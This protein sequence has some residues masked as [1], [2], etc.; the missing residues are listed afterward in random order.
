MLKPAIRNGLKGFALASAASLMFSSVSWGLVWGEAPDPD[1][2]P[3]PQ[4]GA[5]SALEDVIA[6]RNGA[7]ASEAAKRLRNDRPGGRP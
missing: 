2:T 4:E 6:A 7:D 5:T 3:A 1:P